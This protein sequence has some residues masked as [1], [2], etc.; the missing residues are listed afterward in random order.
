MT[1]QRP[2]S[3]QMHFDFS[4]EAELPN[5]APEPQR[6]QSM[7]AAAQQSALGS[8]SDDLM[9]RVV[10]WDNIDRAWRNVKANRGAPGPDGISIAEFPQHFR[11]QWPQIKQQLLDGT[12]RPS[13][14]RRKSIPKPDGSERHLAPIQSNTAQT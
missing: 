5:A 6:G 2:A 12:Y 10:A 1:S 4:D 8:N 14:A 7:V 9:E 11:A 3:R 13:P